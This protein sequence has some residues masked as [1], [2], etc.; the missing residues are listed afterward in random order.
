MT[1]LFIFKNDIPF[2]AENDFLRSESSNSL[3]ILD[4]TVL[5]RCNS[6]PENSSEVKNTL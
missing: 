1:F 5:W 6:R 4:S 2:K 3:D